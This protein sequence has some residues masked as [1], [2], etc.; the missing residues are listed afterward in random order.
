MV[1]LF[2]EGHKLPSICTRN[3]YKKQE[4][5][6]PGCVPIRSFRPPEFVSPYV[7]EEDETD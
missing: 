3:C 1:I 6:D 5:V 2:R 7:G 4:S